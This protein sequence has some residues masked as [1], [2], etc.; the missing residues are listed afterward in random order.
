MTAANSHT[1]VDTSSSIAPLVTVVMPAYNAEKFILD[2]IRSI[3]TQG[4]PSVEI[5]VIDDG[6]VYKR[7]TS[8]VPG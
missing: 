4:Y 6:D 3:H 1:G 5:L 2:A 7:Q 8:L